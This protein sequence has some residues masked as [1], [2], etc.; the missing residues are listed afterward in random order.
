M[1]TSV[2]RIWGPSQ[3]TL[4]CLSDGE[5]PVDQLPAIDFSFAALNY[6]VDLSA[7]HRDVPAIE[8]LNREVVWVGAY[9]DGTEPIRQS[10]FSGC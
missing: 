8:T 10:R 4:S 6:S 9:K 2:K 5:A 7:I 3:W 1:A